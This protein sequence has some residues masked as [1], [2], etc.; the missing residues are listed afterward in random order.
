M[1]DLSFVTTETDGVF[2]NSGWVGLSLFAGNDDEAFFIGAPGNL[3]E[4][5]ID[6]Q[7]AAQSVFSPSITAEA[8]SVSFSYSFDTGE[9]ELSVASSNLSGTATAGLELDRLRIGADSV[10]QADIAIDGITVAV[11]E[12][13][14][15]AALAGIFVLGF[16]VVLRRR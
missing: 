3:S 7:E 16:V 12:P 9:W 6:G 4:W 10:N 2:A 8:Q 5:G 11:P 14:A 13:S 1:L 15:Y